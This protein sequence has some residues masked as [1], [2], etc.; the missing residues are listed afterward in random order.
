M[1]DHPHDGS[2]NTVDPGGLVRYDSQTGRFDEW[3]PGPLRQSGEPFFVP[4]ANGEGEGWLVTYVYDFSEDATDLVILDAT[5]VPA[6]PVA[7]VRMP[8]RVPHGFH[9]IW[10]PA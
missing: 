5:D 4:G 1:L 3:D 2:P 8:R 6:G 10:V 7:E 9:G